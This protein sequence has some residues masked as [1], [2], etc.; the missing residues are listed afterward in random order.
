M[1]SQQTGSKPVQISSLVWSPFAC[2]ATFSGKRKSTAFRRL[3]PME[4]SSSSDD[5]CDRF[6]PDNFANTIAR[7]L[8][9]E[10]ESDQGRGLKFLDRR[11]LN[12]KENIT[13]DSRF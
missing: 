3:I 4:T 11:T 12:I 9:S 2:R 1:H 13:I 10:S 6:G 7:K 5:S 8:D